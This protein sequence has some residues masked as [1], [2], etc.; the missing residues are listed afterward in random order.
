[1]HSVMLGGPNILSGVSLL[2]SALKRLSNPMKWS[3]WV[4]VTK[5]SVIFWISFGLNLVV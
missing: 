4:C 1:M 2:R 3:I 5:T